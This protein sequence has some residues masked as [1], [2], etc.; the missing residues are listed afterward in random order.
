MPSPLSKDITDLPFEEALAELEA[1]VRQMES[2]T[3]KLDEAVATYARGMQLRAH[4]AAR[5]EQARLRVEQIALDASGS[6]NLM[7]FAD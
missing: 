4:C 7:P 6:L 1:L 2:G 5:L 3:V